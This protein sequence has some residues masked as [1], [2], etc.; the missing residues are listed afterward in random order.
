MTTEQKIILSNEAYL[1]MKYYTQ[2]ADGE[3]SGM[4]KSIIEEDIIYVTDVIIFKQKNTSATTDLDDEAM[5]KFF[6]DITKK[7]QK[8]KDWNIWWHSHA[9]MNVFW[10]ATDENTIK[11]HSGMQSF[12]ISIVTNKKNDFKARVDIFPKDTSPFKK[13]VYH[14]FNDIDVEVE[15]DEDKQKK[16]EKLEKVIQKAEEALLELEIECSESKIIETLCQKEIDAK[17]EKPAIAQWR[18]ESFGLNGKYNWIGRW[19]RQN[20]MHFPNK[21]WDWDDEV[22]KKKENFQ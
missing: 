22:L 21:K 17:I 14:T 8:V 19:G 20:K 3:I 9:D 2:L 4:C 15:Y 13:T 18:N 6:F 16:K 7:G 10:S 12:L 5:G 11:E 1:K